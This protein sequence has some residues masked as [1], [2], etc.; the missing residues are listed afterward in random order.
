MPKQLEL[1]VR[2]NIVV[3]PRYKGFLKNNRKILNITITPE[4]VFSVDLVYLRLDLA[5]AYLKS[6]KFEAA[7]IRKAIHDFSVQT[8]F[9]KT[10]S[11]KI[12]HAALR[13]HKLTKFQHLVFPGLLDSVRIFEL[14]PRTVRGLD[15]LMKVNLASVMVVKT[16][17]ASLTPDKADFLEKLSKST[18]RRLHELRDIF[19]QK[20]NEAAESVAEFLVIADCFYRCLLLF[21]VLRLNIYQ[22]D[23]LS[24]RTK[25]FKLGYQE[26]ALIAR[27]VPKLIAATLARPVPTADKF[28]LEENRAFLQGFFANYTK[29]YFAE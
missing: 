11:D 14:N 17:A 29:Q 25:D 9:I 22:R 2:E 27:E 21:M 6:V 23:N 10:A 15:L 28:N 12:V 19:G 5:L 16:F 20:F 18:L 8:E 7:N 26:N 3:V 4:S 24:K 1:C 13:T